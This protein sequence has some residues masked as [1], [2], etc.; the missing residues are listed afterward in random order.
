MSILDEYIARGTDWVSLKDGSAIPMGG[1]DIDPDNPYSTT[2]PARE[3]FD[4]A[5]YPFTIEFPT[6][7]DEVG[8]VAAGVSE[9]DL[10]LID[11]SSKVTATVNQNNIVSSGSGTEA[12]PFLIH[13][14][15][16]EGRVWISGVDGEVHVKITESMI[17]GNSVHGVYAEHGGGIEPTVTIEDCQIGRPYGEDAF[18]K[19]LGVSGDNVTVRRT[20]FTRCGDIVKMPVILLEDV[21]AENLEMYYNEANADYKHVDA[22][23]FDPGAS[24]TSAIRRCFFDTWNEKMDGPEQ[25]GVGGGNAILQMEP[26]ATDVMDITFEDVYGLSNNW[27]IQLEDDIDASSIY[28]LRRVILEGTSDSNGTDRW[29]SNASGIGKTEDYEPAQYIFEDIYHRDGTKL[30]SDRDD[31]AA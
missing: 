21:Y 25:G 8:L 16:V 1:S 11:A 26:D 24:G 14:R 3:P 4:A 5:L 17:G 9:S 19:Q 15:L 6:S 27:G 13:R 18:I 30:V 7:S 12:D 10:T 2:S 20:Y 28:T 29:T 22:L 23:Q 31:T